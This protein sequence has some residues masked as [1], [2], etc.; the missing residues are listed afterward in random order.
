VRIEIA[1][2]T[3]DGWILETI[4]QDRL[5][6][7]LA[8]EDLF[9]SFNAVHGPNGPMTDELPIELALLPLQDV[10]LFSAFARFNGS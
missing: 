8:E 2:G 3:L 4:V 7:G 10:H 6:E 9:S 5:N 1:I